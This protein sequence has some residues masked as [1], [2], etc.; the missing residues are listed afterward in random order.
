MSGN[1]NTDTAI[2][3]LIIEQSLNDAESEISALRNAGLAVHATKAID[4]ESLYEA[5]EETKYDIILCLANHP[6]LELSSTLAVCKK[7]CENAVFIVIYREREYETL[8]QA[9]REGARDIVS[10][11]EQEHL[12]LVVRREFNDLINNRSLQQAREKLHESEQRCTT[13]IDS[14][15]DAIA[16]IHEG[17]HVHANSV[18]LELFGYVDLDEIEGLPILDMISPKEHKRFKSFLRSLS[19]DTTELEIKCQNNDG[20][21]FDATLEFSPATIDEEPCT[22]IIIRD[23]GKALHFLSPGTLAM[24]T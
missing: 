18:Y 16:Y 15:R 3:L 24:L 8:M 12:S 5:L 11:D 13:L 7:A 2:K 9:M 20:T 6:S 22:Q 1:N 21:T 4:Q 23:A 17:M 14:S 19:D 10:A